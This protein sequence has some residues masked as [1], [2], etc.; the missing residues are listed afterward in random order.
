[1]VSK[2]VYENA[3]SRGM[4]ILPMSRRAILA[5]P[6]TTKS[7]GETPVGRTGRMPV[8]RFHTRSKRVFVVT[9]TVRNEKD[10]GVFAAQAARLKRFGRVEMGLHSLSGKTF[11]DIPEGGSPW[12]EYTACLSAMRKFFDDPK[13]SPFVDRPHVRRNRRL[14]SACAKVVKR[15]R[16]GSAFTVHVPFFMSE[17]FFRRHPRLRG[18]RVDH[19]RRSRQ[20]AWAMCLDMPES[21]DILANMV[22][23][24]ARAAPDLGTLTIMTNDAGSGMCW[25]DWL[26]SGPNGPVHCRNVGAGPRVARIVQA[27]DRGMGRKIDIHLIGNFSQQERDAIP[28]YQDDRFYLHRGGGEKH[29][30]QVGAFMDNP[31]LGIVNPLE[32]LKAMERWNDPEVRKVLINFSTNYSRGH[33]K[34]DATLKVIE[35]L[36]AFLAAPACGTLER[37]KL[38][39]RLCE[40]WVGASSAAALLEALVAMDEALAYRQAVLGRFSANYLGVSL[41]YITRPLVAIPENLAPAEESYFLPHVF[42]VRQS[43]ARSDYLDLHGGRL[44]AGTVGEA[45]PSP[46][47]RAVDTLCSL[48]RDAAEQLGRLGSRGDAGFFAR[49]GVSLRIYACIMRSIGNFYSVQVIRDRN[50]ARFAGAEQIPGKVASWTGDN[51]LQ[52][53]NEFMREELDNT[54]ELIDILQSGG[55]SQVQV[56]PTAEQEDTF[57]LGPDLVAQLRKK[58]QIMRRHWKDAE[59]YLA[60]PHK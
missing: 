14:L 25:N 32:I 11:S 3:V 16:L 43:E 34:P 9:A 51:D 59:R 10:F 53:L 19:P 33:N 6:R 27:I 49:M 37:L 55:M 20:E 24:L 23:Q 38:L 54:A 56:A 44:T 52:M 60:T 18:P 41:R 21:Q 39:R 42:N 2:N 40:G 36:E 12:H 48:L 31:V 58:R 7:T 28:L 4:G 17:E 22:R 13:V 45:S 1:M 50:K 46:R 29:I 57:L 30:V 15:L 8:P 47:I 26:Y 5:R 35:I